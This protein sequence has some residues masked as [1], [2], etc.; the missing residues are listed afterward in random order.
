MMLKGA[1]GIAVLF[2]LQV[3]LAQDFRKNYDLP[4]GGQIEIVNVLGDIKVI[5]YDGRRVEVT[6]VKTGAKRA[7]VQIDDFSSGNRIAIFTRYLPFHRG[8]AG[9][10]FELRVP[11]SIA[12]NFTL[13]SPFGGDVA[14]SNVNGRLW[15]KSDRGNVQVREVGGKVSATSI[16]GNVIAEI[17]RTQMPSHMRFSSVSGNIDVVAPPNLD[18]LVNMSSSSGPLRSDFPIDIQ[19]LRYG[20]GRLGRGKLGS[21]RQILDISSVSGRV[22]LVQK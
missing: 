10:E 22:S 6:G 15:A 1:A 21:G 11:K 4:P 3:A 5:G 16:S 17:G 8:D 20:A 7:S 9:V 2:T 13:I 18:A 19:E 12:Y 14:A